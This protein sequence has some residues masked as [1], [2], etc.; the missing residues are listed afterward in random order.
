MADRSRFLSLGLV[1]GLVGGVLVGVALAQPRAASAAG[2]SSSPAGAVANVGAPALAPI[3]TGGSAVSGVASAGTAIA[4]PPYPI[5]AGSPGLAPDHTIVVSGA[6]QADLAADG[7]NH[8]TAEKSAL[9]AALADAKS[10]AGAIA[11]ATGLSIS[12]VLSVSASVS[13]E[14]GLAVPMAGANTSEAPACV[15]GSSGGGAASSGQ[16][17]PIPPVAPVPLPNCLPTPYQPSLSVSV[18]VAYSVH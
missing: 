18:T 12:G 9:A 2:P 1:L 3:S 6:G 11:S 8:A 13:P 5:Y 4:Y 15:Y 10:Q 16:A 14:Y 7:S 17:T